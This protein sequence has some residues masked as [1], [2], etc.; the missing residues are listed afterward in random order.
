M[1][2]VSPSWESVD[3]NNNYRNVKRVPD[4]VGRLYKIVSEWEA[5]FP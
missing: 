3:E 2:L 4:L 1:T 5:L